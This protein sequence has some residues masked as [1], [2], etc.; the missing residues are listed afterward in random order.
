MQGRV[1]SS[2]AY[3]YGFN[4]KEKEADGTADNYDFGA[5]IYDGRLGRW[6]AVDP[7]FEKYPFNSTY[8]FTANSILILKE[9]K[10][11]DYHV[12][13]D[14]IS[15]TITIKAQFQVTQSEDIE[16]NAKTLNTV[17]DAIAMFNNC[18]E[19][20]VSLMEDGVEVRYNVA[21]ELSIVQEN[22]IDC[23]PIN[24]IEVKDSKTILA[25]T[26]ELDAGGYCNDNKIV[27][28]D[29]YND[30]VWNTM[31]HEIGHSLGMGHEDGDG[32]LESETAHTKEVVV[33]EENIKSSLG[34]VGIGAEKASRDLGGI[35]EGQI[36]RPNGPDFLDQNK[37]DEWKSVLQNGKINQSEN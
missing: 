35:G 8:A 19:F 4:G 21:F 10:G 6:L 11:E 37:F 36:T 26:G 17:I 2:A 25:H 14:P 13:Y 1:F 22:A 12:V 30:K 34:R 20:Y 15:K 33:D 23:G 31:K 9:L 18:R 32:Y 5:R 16:K 3:R 28:D 24:T 29:Q 7:L 27:I